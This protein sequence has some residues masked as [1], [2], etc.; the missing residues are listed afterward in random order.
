[1]RGKNDKVDASRIADYAHRFRADAALG[2]PAQRDYLARRP[3]GFRTRLMA[4]ISKLA[5]PVN[6][7]KSFKAKGHLRRSKTPRKDH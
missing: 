4:V 2:T 7:I 6:E 3:D 1:M 5:V